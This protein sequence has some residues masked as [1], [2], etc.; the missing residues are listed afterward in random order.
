M[1]SPELIA[2]FSWAVAAR[3]VRR[4]PHLEIVEEHPGGGTYDCLAIRASEDGSPAESIVHLNRVGSIHVA[5]PTSGWA[6]R[7]A[8]AELVAST[9][10]R[11]ATQLIEHHAGLPQVAGTPP[12]T[13]TTVTYRFVAALLMSQI[14][15]F[16]RWEA[17]YDFGGET[18]SGLPL[19]PWPDRGDRGRWILYRDEAPVAVLNS[20]SG[21]VELGDGS[22][23]DLMARYRSDRRVDALVATVMGSLAV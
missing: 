9:D 15:G 12:A 4:H 6:W 19:P 21:I 7:G 8:W 1:V 11:F 5:G 17:W 3:V 2:A 23:L 20:A 13:P 16:R 14:G 18:W 22:R 10:F